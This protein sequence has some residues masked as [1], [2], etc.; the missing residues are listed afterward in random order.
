M[1]R[2]IVLAF[3]LCSALDAA[4]SLSVVINPSERVFYQS[5]LNVTTID[6]TGAGFKEGMTLEF[7]QFFI[8]YCPVMV[9][10]VNSSLMTMTRLSH[11]WKVGRIYVEAIM[12]D[13]LKYPL[14]EH[15][16]GIVVADIISDINILPASA[17]YHLTKSKK[18]YIPTS[19]TYVGGRFNGTMMAS[20]QLDL[21]PS[22]AYTFGANRGHYPYSSFYFDVNLKPGKSWLPPEFVFPDDN[23]F[24]VPVRVLS[25]NLGPG[26]IE[27]TEPVT[28]GYI[29][30]D[31]DQVKDFVCS[32]SCVNAFDGICSDSTLPLYYDYKES[33]GNQYNPYFYIPP[34]A[35]GTDCTDCGGLDTVILYQNNTPITFDLPAAEHIPKIYSETPVITLTGSGFVEDMTVELS[36]ARS[37]EG[38]LFNITFVSANEI[39]LALRE[40]HFGTFRSISY[41]DIGFLSVLSITSGSRVYY[42]GGR[43]GAKIFEVLKIP[44]I[45]ETNLKIHDTQSIIY[46]HG[47]GFN[48]DPKINTLRLSPTPDEAFTLIS[49]KE[50]GN[51]VNYWG[52]GLKLKNGWSWSGTHFLNDSKPVQLKIVSIDSGAGVVT[53]EMS[54][55]NAFRAQQKFPM[56]VG[57]IER[58]NLDVI[59][60]NTCEYS[61]STICNDRT[62]KSYFAVSDDGKVCAPGTDCCDC[63]GYGALKSVDVF[64]EPVFYGEVKFEDSGTSKYYQSMPSTS[65]GIRIDVSGFNKNTMT[66]NFDPFVDKEDY[67]VIEDFIFISSSIVIKL[68]PKK[69][70][71][72]GAVKVTSI[73][74]KG[75][76][77]LLPNY[78]DK[79]FVLAT[80]LSD[81]VVNAGATPY[82]NTKTKIITI[83]GEGFTGDTQIRLSPTISGSYKPVAYTDTSISLLLHPMASWLPSH[84]KKFGSVEL[85]V[86]EVSSSGGKVVLKRP[87]VIGYIDDDDSGVTCDDSCKH[88]YDG[89]CDYPTNRCSY[90]TDCTDCSIS[91]AMLASESNNFSKGSRASSGNGFINIALI[92]IAC[93]V[94]VGLLYLAYLKRSAI[95]EAPVQQAIE[96]VK[97]VAVPQQDSDFSYI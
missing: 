11:K 64:G 25:M 52:I 72:V 24:R 84:Y 75:G 69:K 8:E 49:T 13:G 47:E 62:S 83:T 29:R 91:M 53:S 71:P 19:A 10:V 9:T 22:D 81:P 12:F 26:L 86:T 44:M 77:K 41:W 4:V 35:V 1:F 43:N 16:N 67:E 55:L 14:I 82:Y 80:F 31:V 33:T 94:V 36:R 79:M 39:R 50:I 95:S 15:G 78:R 45:T 42:Y 20:V 65:E 34:C 48:E 89:V 6:I 7:S 40:L 18:L 90:G 59:C 76:K 73:S 2:L 38:N 88:A 63:G 85:S 27:F 66:L 32:D 70:W 17:T 68:K 46:I 58:D 60:D 92:V 28:I 21:V 54:K 97:Y 87:V 30:R 3:I 57:T 74:V 37:H 56:T 5:Q 96:M 93:V 61:L 51:T 23:T